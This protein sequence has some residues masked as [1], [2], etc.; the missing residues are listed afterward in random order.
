MAFIF[1][2]PTAILLI[3]KKVKLKILTSTILYATQT[4]IQGLMKFWEFPLWLSS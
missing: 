3:K 4:N 2:N 1:I